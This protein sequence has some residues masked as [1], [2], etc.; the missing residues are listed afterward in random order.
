MRSQLQRLRIH[1]SVLVF[2]YGSDE[3]SPS[4]IERCAHARDREK[5]RED[6]ER[7]ERVFVCVS[8]CECFSVNRIFDREC[9]FG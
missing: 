1:P 3:L 2:F 9:L 6:R 4:D 8:V 7:R 5:E